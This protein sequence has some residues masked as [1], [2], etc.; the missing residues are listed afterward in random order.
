MYQYNY[1]GRRWYY[2]NGKWYASVTSFVKNSLPTPPHLLKWYKDN[3]A[4]FIEDTLDETS[5]Y[6]T[7]LHAHVE[8]LLRFGEF[9]VSGIESEKELKHIASFAQF[10]YDWEVEPTHIETK[11][12]HDATR[13]FPLNF[14]GTVDLVADTNKG[15]C[16]IDFKSGGIYE[17]HRYQMM[18]YYLAWVQKT[19]GEDNISSYNN[20]SFVNV[21]PKEW[22]TNPTYEAKVWRITDQD[23]DRLSAMCT[24]YEFDY[25]KNRLIL[26]KLE[27]GKPPK[28]ET[29]EAE[30]WINQQTNDLD[31]LN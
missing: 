10:L 24:I 30:K 22:R 15:T 3:S 27:L 31:W 18:C 9:D 2:E 16:I 11:L 26:E 29:M 5:E 25:P 14:A 19:S 28:Y 6:G 23:W 21:R 7:R 20:V 1:E 17:N 8:R 12:K 4:D 13:K